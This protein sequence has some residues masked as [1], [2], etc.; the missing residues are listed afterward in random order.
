MGDPRL[1][2]GAQPRKSKDL[3]ARLKRDLAEKLVADR[4]YANMAI[5]HVD[6]SLYANA[7]SYTVRRGQENIYAGERRP[8][9]ADVLDNI[10]PGPDGL[11]SLLTSI[12]VRSECLD[13][14]PG[15]GT[16]GTLLE[17]LHGEIRYDERTYFLLAGRW[18]EV[19]ASYIDLVT[20]DFVG[21]IENL[22]LKASAIGLRN[23]HKTE[24]EGAYNESSVAGD[25]VINGDR[26]MTDN[27]EL[28]DT[29]TCDGERTYIVHVKRDFDVKV[30]DVRSQIIN[31]AN[32]IENDLRLGDPTRLK[33]HHATLQRKGR[34]TLTESEFLELFE[35]PQD[36][37]PR[38]RHRHQAG[39]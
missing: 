28:F 36:V 21:L 17:H 38:L 30:R 16:H 29:L 37:R 39:P 8:D 19:D 13:Y 33:R 4:D 14:G 25:L 18:Y 22:D 12:I 31:S 15:V 6:A 26:V 11:A 9:L 3:I 23:W 27:V 10:D 2:Q 32:I 20:R 35:R 24:S 5:T 7:A 1:N 34:T